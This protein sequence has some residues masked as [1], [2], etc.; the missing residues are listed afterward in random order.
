MALKL[1]IDI[2]VILFLLGLISCGQDSPFTKNVNT[3]ASYS[4]I[5]ITKDQILRWSDNNLESGLP[6]KIASEVADDLNHDEDDV[7]MEWNNVLPQRTF[8]ALPFPTVT[9]REKTSLNSYFDDEMGI[10]KSKNW[11]SELGPGVLAITQFFG[12]RRTQGGH[13]YIEFQHADIIVNYRDYSFSSNML[14]ATTYDLPSVLLHEMGHFVGL[15]H[16]YTTTKSVM[17]PAL[18]RNVSVRQL[19]PVDFQHLEDNYDGQEVLPMAVAISTPKT[20]SVQGRFE[21]RADGDC[22]HFISGQNVGTHHL[23]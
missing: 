13:E 20:E 15:R 23:Q 1:L 18:R 3:P 19:Y 6:L 12:V 9:N 10:Y 7:A 2:I 16:E 21:L 5:E 4:P 14:D 8:F 17:W 22:V 11:F